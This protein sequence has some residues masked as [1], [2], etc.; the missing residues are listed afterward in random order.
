M[1]EMPLESLALLTV[2]A[3]CGALFFVVAMLDFVGGGSVF[4]IIA[5]VSGAIMSFCIY[6]LAVKDLEIGKRNKNRAS[7][8]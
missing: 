3:I 8:V 1:N 2:C 6:M 5:T 4:G 7:Q